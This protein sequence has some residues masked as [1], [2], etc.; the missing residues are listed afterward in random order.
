MGFKR[1]SDG[2][3]FFQRSSDGDETV[4]DNKPKR[5][6]ARPQSMKRMQ[7]TA[8]LTRP[9]AN[10]QD[11]Q[12]EVLGMLR[13]LNERLQKTQAERKEMQA[14]LAAN[15]EI[16][17]KL[18][19]QAGNTEKT[20]K[21]LEEKFL[22]DNDL[23]VG[24]AARAQT[25][26]Q[27][28]FRELKETRKIIMDLEDKTDR[29]DRNVH[30]LK[31]QIAKTKEI[32]T[33]LEEKEAMFNALEERLS[34]T[35]EKQRQMDDRLEESLSQQALMMRKIEKTIEDRTRFMRKIERIEETV[36]QTQDSLNAKAM[37]LLTDQGMAAR[38][39]TSAL[40][41]DDLGMVPSDP[42][43]DKA[44]A[45]AEKQAQKKA[46]KQAK[47]QKRAE[48]K[49]Q[50]QSGM[51]FA[52]P[53]ITLPEINFSAVSDKIMRP[54][55]IGGAAM[56]IILSLAT[57]WGVSHIQ[58]NGMPEFDIKMPEFGSLFG[59]GSSQ[60]AGENDYLA[61]RITPQDSSQ[62][63]AQGSQQGWSIDQ[64]VSSFSAERN[65]QSQIDDSA[66]TFSPSQKAEDQQAA[67]SA[68]QVIPAED[69]TNANE[70]QA[71]TQE[72]AQDEAQADDIAA[73]LDARSGMVEEVDD[74]GMIPLQ[75]QEQLAAL[76]NDNPDEL[77]SVLNRIEPASVD[78]VAK[79]TLRP[80]PS[81]KVMADIGEPAADLKKLIKADSSLPENIKPIENK[82]FAGIPEAQHD[83]AAIYTAGHGGVE[84]DYK[85]AAFW[86]EQAGKGGIANARYNLGV[87][88]HQGL[89]VEQDLEKA[90]NWYQAAADMNHPEA[91]Y[92]LGIAYIE[93]I[94]VEYDPVR[95]A[96]YFENAANDGIME[97]A[98]NL[99]LIHENGLLGTPKPDEALMWYKI[100]SDAGSPEAKAALEQLAKVLD[101]RLKDVNALAESMMAR[102]GEE[103][104]EDMNGTNSA[105]SGTAQSE[106]SKK[107][108]ELR[109]SD[110][111]SVSSS[112]MRT[113]VEADDE[114]SK[115]YASSQSLTMQI[116]SYLMAL[117]L[118]PGP[119]DG[120]SGPLTSD[121]IRSYQAMYGLPKDGKA[122]QELL[123][124]MIESAR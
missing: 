101:I 40:D 102:R 3:I 105:Q 71:Q 29:A 59:A 83:L 42:L 36:L 14:E 55:I 48:K 82:A 38:Q 61:A 4:Q 53:E 81:S 107:N 93:G 110:K 118:Y 11:T 62:D 54:G 60:D 17:K 32:S 116:Q 109:E 72:E 41:M 64:D 58:K 8:P 79:D 120:S 67:Q 91:Q 123:G 121:A 33:S 16:I 10:T 7:N 119:A 114:V 68:E 20:Y 15:R 31:N 106:G 49:S 75:D 95:A 96:R 57:G 46:E 94:G 9:G 69:T 47:K 65:T 113:S 76:L 25:L 34:K 43:S 63:S 117:G 24:K 85:R 28:A 35:E 89:G 52:L 45:K 88:H 80:S 90:L 98:Y 104:I 1:T 19:E 56:L 99:G 27:E 122:T 39:G 112:R 18:E 87:L 37:V 23:G 30:T 26:A 21:T 111:V 13:A 124:H 70:E 5:G 50:E 103:A 115:A 2:R 86:F 66:I 74:I 44:R 77:A 84:Q 22:Q 12:M 100:A 51:A 6:E 108:D 97:A 92:N 78:P 73:S